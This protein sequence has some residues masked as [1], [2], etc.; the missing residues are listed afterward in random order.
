MENLSTFT[1]TNTTTENITT[2]TTPPTSLPIPEIN[3]TSKT[4]FDHTLSYASLSIRLG[5]IFVFVWAAVMMSIDPASYLHYMPSWVEVV[6]PRYYALHAFSAYEI[7]LCI[8]LVSGK[9]TFYSGLL[10]ALTIA[11]LTIVNYQYFHILFR[12]VAI[13]ASALALVFIST[14][15][16]ST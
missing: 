15:K 9:K 16:N 12:N 4:N 5:L 11:A 13:F 10:A 14:H 2:L 3:N 8:W 6:I 7:L 1:P